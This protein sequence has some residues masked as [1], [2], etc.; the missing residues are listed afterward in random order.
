MN[1]SSDHI[2]NLYLPFVKSDFLI[3]YLDMNGICAS[4][5]SAC[6]AGSL[7]PSHVL[8]NMYDSHRANHSIRF[9][10]GFDNEIE[11][12]DQLVDILKELQERM[13][14]EGK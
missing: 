10:F 9:S 6:T 7:E 14:N 4:T 1:I 11:E 8:G 12:L 3:T 2:L 5:G 13:L